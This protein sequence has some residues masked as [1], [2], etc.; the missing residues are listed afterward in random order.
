MAGTIEGLNKAADSMAYS[1]VKQAPMNRCR[2]SLTD[3]L[4]A[5]ELRD[6]EQQDLVRV[7]Y[8]FSRDPGRPARYV[9]E[10]LLDCADVIE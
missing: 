8:A 9:Q 4:Y 3:Q 6:Y 1:M 10:A 7:E 5:D 2:T